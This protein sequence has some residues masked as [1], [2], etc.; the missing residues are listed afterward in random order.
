MTTQD[1]IAFVTALT[2]CAR[3]F[4]KVSD[5]NELSDGY[6]QALQDLPLDAVRA[7]FRQCAQSN[8]FF[9]R[10]VEIRDAATKTM[11]AVAAMQGEPSAPACEDCQSTGWRHY[12]CQGIN[13]TWLWNDDGDPRHAVH[14]DDIV[15]PCQRPA[16]HDAHTYVRRC[17]CRQTG[18]QTV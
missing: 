14:Q 10:P 6:W 17:H 11:R 7:G 3:I 5:I 2:D 4:R 13:S 16:R 15:S 9:P 1:R 8:R 18:E 12:A